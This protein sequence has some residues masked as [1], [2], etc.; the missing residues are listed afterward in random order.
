MQNFA[1]LFEQFAANILTPEIRKIIAD[2]FGVEM[3]VLTQLGIGFNPAKNAFVFPERDETGQIV[4][5]C[6]RFMN[7]TKRMLRGSKR[8]LIY[9][10]NSPFISERG[11]YVP[12]KHNWVRLQE[13]NVSCP[14]CGKS[15]WCLVS[16]NNPADP[17]AVVCGR[18]SE[19]SVTRLEGSGFLHIRKPNGRKSRDSSPLPKF[20]GPLL[21]TEG[22]SDTASAIDM[23]FMA[24]GKPSAEFNS[25]VLV[26]LV[27]DYNVILVGDNDAGAGKR[28]IDAT[29]EVLR[30]VCRSVIKVFPPEKY[31][32]LRHWKNQIQL[33][34]ATFLQWV[35]EHGE[36]GTDP[37]ILP[38]SAA[39]TV[40]KTWLDSKAGPDGESR[41]KLFE[42]QWVRFN[43]SCY[44]DVDV[45][46]LRGDIYR[47]LKNKKYIKVTQSGKT[48]VVP[49]QPN[50]AK[51]SDVLDAL[52]QWCPVEGRPPCWVKKTPLP[53]PKNLIV[54]K[55]GILD[56]TEYMNGRIK[57]YTPNPTLFT[58]HSLPYEF[59]ENAESP[60]WENFLVDI[61]DYDE[62]RI[63]LLQQWFG[64]NC[65]PDMSLEKMLFCTGRP[66]SGKGTI[67]NV[68]G[69]MLGRSQWMATSLRGL[70]RRF[71]TQPLIGKLAAF[72]SDARVTD[73]ASS[74]A[75]LE[76]LLHI[77]GGDPIGIERKHIGRLS[78]MYLT[79]RFTI[80]TNGLLEIRDDEDALRSKISILHF[81]KSY[82][83]RED[84]TLKPRL[85]REAEDGKLINFALRGLKDLRENK[86]FI[87]PE[88][89]K[90]ILE[91]LRN[92]N[93]PI[94]EFVDECCEL[95][96]PD[97]TD[98]FVI[99]DVIYQ[100][101][102]TWCKQNGYRYGNSSHFGRILMT[103]LPG[104]KAHRKIVLCHEDAKFME[105]VKE[106][107][108]V[109][110]NIRLTREAY[111][112]YLGVEVDD[113]S[114]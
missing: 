11:K 33:D 30:P 35:E 36:K 88:S 65:V 2:E 59:D 74:Q 75:A 100:A 85:Q 40:A 6:Q 68:L 69:S 89:S 114:Y 99:K 27:K 58:F 22:Y 23:G 64:Y 53:D 45:N 84:F 4:G 72:I 82:K 20:E 37:N 91:G 109:Y 81:T 39:S 49:F 1:T 87:V 92:V 76:T 26:P 52:N 97:V 12:G 18:V 51:V 102:V 83:G 90:L 41:I 16:A 8:G 98:Y 63:R 93:T 77:I 70:A 66:R 95:A 34:K 19:G 13:A 107:R 55:N 24:I 29:F 71:G 7:G 61:F 38:D 10:I 79:C 96:P 112:R 73:F 3:N 104:I 110:M 9:P 113:K 105:Q 111:K 78:N 42:G 32:D 21:I 108:Y 54:F 31:K 86:K 50:R 67:I 17:A 60:L 47:F 44:E 62:E 56:V 43:G 80:A 57:L 14:I 28:G 101:W 5:L 15:D 103:H 48:D 46:I 25:K 106:R 94:F